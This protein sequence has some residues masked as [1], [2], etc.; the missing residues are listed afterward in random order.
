LG[1]FCG[2]GEDEEKKTAG[3][4]ARNALRKWPCGT[5]NEEADLALRIIGLGVE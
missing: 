3:G 4:R 1:R 5:T 2:R